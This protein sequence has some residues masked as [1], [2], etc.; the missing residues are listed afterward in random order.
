MRVLAVAMQKGGV[1]KTTTVLHVAVGLADLG[2][3]VLV[4]DLDPQG[5]QAQVL[6]VTVD[7]E[8]T[9]YQVLMGG[10]PLS[11]CVYRTRGLD[12]LPASPGWT[13]AD[14]ELAPLFD[15]RQKLRSALASVEERYDWVVIDTPPNLGALTANALAAAHRILIPVTTHQAAVNELPKFLETFELARRHLN[16]GLEIAGLLPTMYAKRVAQD[17]QV[18]EMLRTNPMGIPC[19]D[20]I[21]RTTRL[22]ECFSRCAPAY[23]YDREASWPYERLTERIAL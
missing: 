7:P 8:R 13:N 19:Y 10:E 21:P 20:P 16:P 23:D 12:L 1:G 3:R 15:G 11:S 4:V 14:V 6:G 22:T 2:R 17:E 9:V 18:L 5:Q